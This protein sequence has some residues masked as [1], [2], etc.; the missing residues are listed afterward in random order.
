MYFPL[1][2]T[3]DFKVVQGSNASVNRLQCR[4]CGYKMSEPKVRPRPRNPDTCPHKNLSKRGAT[5]NL[6]N[7]YCEDCQTT[8]DKV[9]R[10]QFNQTVA[11]QQRMILASS[12]VKETTKKLVD[13]VCLEIQEARTIIRMFEQH[14]MQRID[15]ME[16]EETVD[17]SELMVM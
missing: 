11:L 4:V 9:T 15:G 13:D 7:W 2:D 17:S 3:C 8:V 16:S 12:R 14:G 1:C 10:P 6:V 5:K